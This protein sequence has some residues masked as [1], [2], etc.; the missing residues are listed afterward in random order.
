M[1]ER[2]SI[3]L[4]LLLLLIGSGLLLIGIQPVIKET[5]NM[6]AIG[7]LAL[8]VG[9]VAGLCM[10]LVNKEV[11]YTI[12]TYRSV[13]RYYTEAS[14]ALKK[15]FERVSRVSGE[16]EKMRDLYKQKIKQLDKIDAHDWPRDS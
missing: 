12:G 6:Y 5:V 15:E 13:F 14:R 16:Y 4:M 1:I 11:W 9:A 10:H 3:G 2:I 8:M 7:G